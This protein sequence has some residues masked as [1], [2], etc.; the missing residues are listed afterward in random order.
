MDFFLDIQ[1]EEKSV[2]KAIKEAAKRNDMGSAKVIFFFL[3][4]LF[5]DSECGRQF[6]L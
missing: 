2:Q 4:P 3:V 5:C 6:K 1:R